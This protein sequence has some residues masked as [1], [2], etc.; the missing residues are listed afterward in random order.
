LIHHT[1]P[2]LA[3]EK[4]ALRAAA[5]ALRAHQP[6]EASGAVARHVLATLTFPEASRI[7]GVWPLP[8]ELDLRPL[9]HD[10]HARGHTILLPQ[11]PPRGEPLVFRRWAPGCT[12]VLERFGT[13]RPEGDIAVP[14]LIFVPLLAFDAAGHR[15]GYGGGYYDRT[16]AAHP[17]VP[18]V[19]VA[20]AALRV[21]RV[22]AGPWDQPLPMIISE[23]GVE[24]DRQGP[25]V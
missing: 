24:V 6:A 7:G 1:D 25:G 20:F 21:P 4:A 12:M 19:G 8:G 3:A 18:A 16:L 2:A 23:R 22:P 17:G 5:L 13:R 11:T 10:L 14:M 15:L 9:W